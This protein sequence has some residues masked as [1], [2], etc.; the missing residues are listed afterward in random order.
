MMTQ[1]RVPGQPCGCALCSS[2]KSTAVLTEERVSMSE[3]WVQFKI[4]ASDSS[5]STSLASLRNKIRRHE[6]SRA[7]KI[8]QELIEKGEQDLVRNMVNRDCVCRDR[9][10]IQNSI[11]SCEDEPTLY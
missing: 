2:T 4:Q 1:M 3:E 10:C 9:F 7:H 8:A 6:V 11:L 5:R